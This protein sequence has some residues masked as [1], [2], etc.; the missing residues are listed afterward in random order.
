MMVIAAT[1]HAFNSDP[2]AQPPQCLR[3]TYAS[4]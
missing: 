4:E 1:P 3:N 2:C